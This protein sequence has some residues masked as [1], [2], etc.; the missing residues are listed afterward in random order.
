MYEF[1]E[2]VGTDGVPLWRLR[3]R[4]G[5][6]CPERTPI[7]RGRWRPQ[8]D[9]VRVTAMLECGVYRVHRPRHGIE[10]FAIDGQGVR[11]EVSLGSVREWLDRLHEL[12]TEPAP[13]L[14][15]M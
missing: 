11:H 14:P 1:D 9:S 8:T 4:D 6:P 13:G 2:D 15:G 7:D 10:Y 12:E 3:L 5:C